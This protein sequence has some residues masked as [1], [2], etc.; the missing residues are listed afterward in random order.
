M[1]MKVRSMSEQPTVKAEKT[2]SL[3]AG[4]SVTPTSMKLGMPGTILMSH[5][6]RMFRITFLKMRIFQNL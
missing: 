6:V 1:L 5:E 3:P 4:S 2:D